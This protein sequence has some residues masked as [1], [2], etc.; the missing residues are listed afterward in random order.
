MAMTRMPRGSGWVP[1]GR[2]GAGVGLAVFALLVLAPPAGAE[3]PQRYNCPGG[4]DWIRMS[5]T[6]CVQQRDTLPVNGKIG[7]DG[8]ALCIDPFAGIYE[9]RPTTDGKGVPGNPATSYAYLLECVTQQELAARQARAAEAARLGDASRL[10]ADGGTRPP[11]GELLL[12]GALGSGALVFAALPALR[13][14]PGVVPPAPAGPG[15]TAEPEP[16]TPPV[17][18]AP[19]DAMPTDPAELRQRIARL[20]EIDKELVERIEH[21]RTEAAAGRLTPQDYVEWAGIVS[22][23]IGWIP[24]IQLPAGI[25][26]IAANLAGMVGEAYDTRDI[27][28]SIREG[29]GE[30]ARLRGILAVERDACRAALDVAEHPPKPTVPLVDPALLPDQALRDER[31]RAHRRTLD[32]CDR[33]RDATEKWIELRTSLR[34]QEQRVDWLQDHLPDLDTPPTRELA[35]TENTWTNLLAGINSYALSTRETDLKASVAG[36]RDDLLAALERGASR[37]ANLALNEAAASGGAVSGV[38]RAG[39]VTSVVSVVTAAV[40]MYEWF[41]E[42]NV[43]QQRV[44]VEQAMEGMRYEAGRLETQIRQA[45]QRMNRAGDAVEAEASRRRVL[46]A[47][48]DMRAARG[49]HLLWPN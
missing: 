34:Q 5:G 41:R 40:S 13:R 16:V 36:A 12:L 37:D 18:E 20:D 48:I 7:Y 19:A 24:A 45:E 49:G 9:T 30:M 28:R 29:L 42:Q 23:L 15:A 6:A 38:E 26:S 11:P 10:L 8:H 43:E 46:S 21:Y 39:H 22:D 44:I 17:V 32:A 33:Q 14:R 4:F 2:L 47:E 27:D 35:Q 1:I 31:A 3:D 25:L